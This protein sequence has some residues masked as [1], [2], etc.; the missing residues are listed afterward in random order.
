MASWQVGRVPYAG[1]YLHDLVRLESEVRW[2]RG[3]RPSKEPHVH[4]RVIASICD[5]DQYPERAAGA[6]S[7]PCFTS[8]AVLSISPMHLRMQLAL[9]SI[10]CDKRA[11]P[12]P[13]TSQLASQYLARA[14]DNSVGDVNNDLPT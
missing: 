9:R 12:F 5:A 1:R 4:R 8:R 10:G 3:P 2:G 14:A 7:M 6:F 11:S 13:P